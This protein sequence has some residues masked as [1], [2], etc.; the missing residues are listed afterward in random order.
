MNFYKHYIGDFQR[1]TG[2]LSLT[3]RGA[4]RALLDHHYATEKPLP[5]DATA[6]CRLVGA[7]SKAERDAVQS[8]LAQFWQETSDGWI[9]ERAL[10]EM[11]KADHQREVNRQIAEAREARRKAAREG[12]EQSTNRATNDQPNQTP[13]TRHQTDTENHSEQRA[14]DPEAATRGHQPTQAGAVCRA[15]RHAGLQQ[16]NPGDPRLL[17]LIAQG[18]T[19]AEFVGVAAEAAASG[20]GW[21][22]MLAVVQARRADAAAIALAPRVQPPS[23]TVPSSAAD[24]TQRYLAEQAQHTRSAPPAALLARVGKAVK[25]TS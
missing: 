17:A 12:H 13:D 1:D 4:Y 16:T 3:E 11:G 10:R 6:L 23:P 5:K 21:A 19:E 20:K 22:W 25:V 2:H 7:V 8:V 9:N 14:P 15:M 18:A 24:D